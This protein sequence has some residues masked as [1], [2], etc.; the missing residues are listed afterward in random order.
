MLSQSTVTVNK[1]PQKKSDNK[2]LGVD[3]LPWEF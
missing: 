3:V 1:V 2:A